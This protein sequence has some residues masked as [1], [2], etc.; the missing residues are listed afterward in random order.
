MKPDP[1]PVREALE[2]LGVGRAWMAGDTP[3][4]LAAARG[5]GVVPIGVV[6]PGDDPVIAG[7]AL[8]GAAVVLDSTL[9]LLEVLDAAGV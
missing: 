2:R 3:D 6:A 9:D 8:A 5:A 1:A 7:Q 4:D